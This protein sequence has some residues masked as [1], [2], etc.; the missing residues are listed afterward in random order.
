MPEP[1]ILDGKPCT[2]AMAAAQGLD[3]KTLTRL[4][5]RGALVRLFTGVYVDADIPLTVEI[6]VEAARLALSKDMVLCD[7]TAAW[8]WGVDAFVYAELDGEMP[9]ECCTPRA[10]RATERAGC[11]GGS[12]D[13]SPEDWCTIGGVRVTTPL[14]TALDLACNLWPRDALA[15]MDALARGHGFTAHDLARVLPRYVRRR[16]VVQA[17]RLVP[18]VDPRA[19]SAP[20]SWTRE[21]IDLHGLPMPELQ[22][23]VLVDGVPTYRLDLAYVRAKIAVEYDGEEFHTSPADR[24]RDAD[25]RAWLR[26]HGWYVIV[27]TKSSFNPEAVDQWVRE[28]REV[29][30]VRTRSHKRF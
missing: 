12:R 1:R 13:L 11:D 27:L 9:L 4:V 28:L 21:V 18:L 30:T 29:L 5:E 15:A 14:R 24:Q 25:R 3:R 16:G 7:R 22:H 26:A 10:R 8:I 2:T 19:E 20:E 23:W 17:R 6:R